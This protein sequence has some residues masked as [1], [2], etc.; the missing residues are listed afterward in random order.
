MAKS[1]FLKK[2][3]CLFLKEQNSKEQEEKALLG[4]SILHD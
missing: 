3:Y 4:K 2:L 1:Q